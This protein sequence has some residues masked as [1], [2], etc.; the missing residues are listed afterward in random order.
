M[1]DNQALLS[2]IWGIAIL[3]GLVAWF[4]RWKAS[5]RLQG[6][7]EVVDFVARSG[8]YHYERDGDDLPEKVVKALDYLQYALKQKSA[9]DRARVYATGAGALADAMGEAAAARGFESGR[10]YTEPTDGERRVDMTMEN[11]REIQYLAH[12][13][14]QHQMPNY[15][16]IIHFPF[17]SEEKALR[18][19]AAIEKLEYA[20][21]HREGDPEYSDSLARNMLIWNHWPDEQKV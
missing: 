11:W 1:K 12:I 9:V 3:V 16:R 21:N 8:S 7:R 20:I 10:R 18:A 5:I 19:E 4:K 13:G 6:M 2:I 14:F 17:D 15:E